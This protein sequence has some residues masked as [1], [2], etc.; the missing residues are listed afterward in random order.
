[1]A[2]AAKAVGRELM[3]EVIEYF[4][5]QLE[6]KPIE[7]ELNKAA[8]SDLIRKFGPDVLVMATGATPR[9]PDHLAV[10]GSVRDMRTA[11]VDTTSLG[12]EVTLYTEGRTIDALTVADSLAASGRSVTI[13]TPHARV[14]DDLD[15]GSMNVIRRRLAAK[16]V[17]I[18]PD[19]KLVSIEDGSAEFVDVWAASSEGEYHRVPPIL[20]L[21]SADLVC[22][23][24]DEANNTLL[25]QVEDLPVVYNIG[26]SLSPRGMQAAFW[27]AAGVA[28]RI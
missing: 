14:G 17:Q 15:D 10:N 4:K 25:H 26:D 16:G 11:L 2:T 23:F 5:L 27:D 22:D 18:K 19:L 28:L 12:D 1:V 7:L 3:G 6:T 24:G 21:P 9:R 8:T 13:V 20:Q